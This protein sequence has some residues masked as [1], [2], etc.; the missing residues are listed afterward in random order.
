MFF[1]AIDLDN[2]LM[3]QSSIKLTK[4]SRLEDDKTEPLLEKS[5]TTETGRVQDEDGTFVV[6]RQKPKNSKDPSSSSR[7]ANIDTSKRDFFVFVALNL[8]LGFFLQMLKLITGMVLL[9]FCGDTKR[10]RVLF[11]KGLF[12]LIVYISGFFYGFTV[13]WAECNYDFNCWSNF[14]NGTLHVYLFVAKSCIRISIILLLLSLLVIIRSFTSKIDSVLHTNQWKFDWRDMHVELVLQSYFW[15][16][17]HIVAHLVR[18]NNK[19]QQSSFYEI[20]HFVTGGIIVFLF[21]VQLLTTLSKR[22][23]RRWHWLIS[24]SVP[25]IIFLHGRTYAPLLFLFLYGLDYKINRLPVQEALID[26]KSDKVICLRVKVGRNIPNTPGYYCQVQVH[27]HLSSYTLFPD[28]EYAEFF[29]AKEST[30]ANQLYS[31][32]INDKAHMKNALTKTYQINPSHLHGIKI[33]G[34]FE[35]N[36]YLSRQEFSKCY[37]TSGTDAQ[38]SLIQERIEKWLVQPRSL[39]IFIM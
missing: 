27:G 15:S 22:L 19:L 14:S 17:G 18:Y 8:F 33:W 6:C 1:L 38:S 26:N 5:L 36:D 24:M 2:R 32:I 31:M 7:D 9:L 13:S 39:F 30:I 23:F 21:L 12:Y 29:V 34:P 16:V 10:N 37:I 11:W 20:Y 28:G 25:V 3:E 35:S 4:Y